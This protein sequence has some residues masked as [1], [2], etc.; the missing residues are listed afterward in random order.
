MTT[1][2]HRSRRS[3]R[4]LF[5]MAV[6]V[7]SFVVFVPAQSAQAGF[8]PILGAG[9]TWSQIAVNQWRADTYSKLGLEVNYN[10]VGST[11][12]R[13]LFMEDQ[14]DFANSE[15][16]FL[17]N[18][19][20]FLRQ[21][22]KAYQYLPIVAGGT[23][24][25]YNL[26]IGGQRIRNLQLSW[27]PL[28]GIFTGTIKYWDDP[29]IKADNR[30]NGLA[31]RLP[32][33]PIIPVVRSDGSGTSAQFSAYLAYSD[34]TSSSTTWGKFCRQWQISPCGSTSFWPIFSTAVG[35]KGSDGVAN[36]VAASTNNGAIGYVEA[37]YAL[38]RGF[39]VASILN[40][41]G[42]YVQPTWQADT[43]ALT[44]ATFNADRTQNLTGVYQ[45]GDAAAY[46]ISSYSYMIT[47]TIGFDPG[48][49]KTL[50]E[51]I[52]YFACAGQQE[53]A[54]LGY[55]PLPP[56]LVEADFAAVRAIPG[57]PA[58]PPLSQCANPTITHQKIQGPPS[59]SS[60]PTATAGPSPTA[61]VGPGQGHQGGNKTQGP[62]ATQSA[63]VSA[64]G[65]VISAAEAAARQT[66]VL[67]SV[68][69]VRPGSSTV[70]VW[71]AVD[72]VALIVGACWYLRRR[73]R[74]KQ[75][76]RVGPASNGSNGGGPR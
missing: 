13:A 41:S 25:M 21:E 64:G 12:G 27:R 7:G 33:I 6:V 34:G 50:G 37:G 42:H 22:H 17:P 72:V 66:A 28:V 43:L 47:Q 55:A 14:V 70:G 51:F 52:L 26:T 8:A 19:V 32:H 36:Y 18:E 44:H 65:K 11:A 4:T 67:H 73:E 16:P 35:Q 1:R 61:S 24:A 48:K 75:R 53:A 54:P 59:Q 40:R 57:A 45:A 38:Q 63:A 2:R 5:A 31:S 60:G 71:L 20:Q 30:S 9:S 23:S 74:R 39:P 56:N 62:Q 76:V 3:S 49:G 15:I 58:P 10:G 46:P 68:A 29:A 69:L